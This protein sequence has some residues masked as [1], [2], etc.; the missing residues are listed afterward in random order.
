MVAA[1]PAENVTFVFGNLLRENG[2]G[3]ST[4]TGAHLALFKNDLSNQFPK[5]LD[6]DITQ[7]FRVVVNDLKGSE[8][9]L[10]DG[11]G[12]EALGGHTLGTCDR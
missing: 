8:A 9:I 7:Q 5:L 6:G 10:L 2:S 12:A 3:V 1:Q 11:G 4:A